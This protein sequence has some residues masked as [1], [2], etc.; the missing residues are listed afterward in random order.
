MGYING[1]VYNDRIWYMYVDYSNVFNL[2]IYFNCILLIDCKSD[3]ND[4]I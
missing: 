2:L 3:I 4:E 1:G